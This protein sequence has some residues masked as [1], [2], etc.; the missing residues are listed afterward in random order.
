MVMGRGDTLSKIV[1]LK[2]FGVEY[3]EVWNDKGVYLI[4][5]VIL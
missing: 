2:M 4:V 5:W 1:L 3:K